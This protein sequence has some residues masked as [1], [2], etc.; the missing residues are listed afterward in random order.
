[1]EKR[2]FN[3]E[4]I[5]TRLQTIYLSGDARR[6][7]TAG[8]GFDFVI[9][10][11]LWAPLRDYRCGFTDRS[12]LPTVSCTA[13]SKNHCSTAILTHQSAVEPVTNWACANDMTEAHFM[14]F[15]TPFIEPDGAATSASTTSTTSSSSTS[16]AA[17]SSTVSDPAATRL[18][19][20]STP[21]NSTNPASST[22]GLGSATD[23]GGQSNGG[24]I[25]NN[26]GAIIGGVVGCV[27]LLCGFGLA[28]VWLVRW[29]RNGN[30][31]GKPPSEHAS[32]LRGADGDV[33]DFKPELEALGRSELSARGPAPYDTATR[34]P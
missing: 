18:T 29:N 1:M 13:G 15:T 3:A 7:R 31:P 12:S 24:G 16:K 14:G 17:T 32:T 19:T 22:S 26:I 2:L 34:L 21:P 10:S 33:L 23:T 25:T 5:A 30:T 9:D 6:I 27:A 4:V 11:G 28:T 8:F 20:P